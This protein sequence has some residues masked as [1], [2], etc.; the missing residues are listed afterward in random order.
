VPIA[1]IITNT[2]YTNQRA[3]VVGFLE[4]YQTYANIDSSNL[5][6]M[7]NDVDLT[8]NSTITRE[9]TKL[10]VSANSFWGMSQVNLRWTYT[11]NGV[12][13]TALEI[14]VNAEGFVTYLHDDRALYKIGD[15][16]VNISMEQAVD[17]AIENLRTYSYKMS[18]GSV[19]RDFKADKDVTLPVLCVVAVDYELRPYWDI[20][21]YLDEVYPGNVFGIKA[22]IWA[23]TGEIISYGNMADGGITSIDDVNF[24]DTDSSPINMWVFVGVTAVAVVVAALAIGAVVKKRHK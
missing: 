19:V 6:A 18:D 2:Q 7:L 8:K 21:L 15:T 9:N 17:I 1:Q 4:K 11:V 3:A 12:D 5:I 16:S 20:S 13:Y 10:V 24:S 23:N 22:F 14:S